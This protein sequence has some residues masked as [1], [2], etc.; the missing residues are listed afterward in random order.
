MDVVL[1]VAITPAAVR[2]VLVEGENADGVTVDYDS[3]EGVGAARVERVLAGI[4]GT[5]AG[6]VE[7]GHRVSGTGVVWTDYAAAVE[8]RAALR[9]RDIEGVTLVSELHAA[10]ALARAVG[11]TA[12]WNSTAL[13]LLDRDTATLAVVRTADGAVTRVQ[14]R[15]LRS[16]DDAGPAEMVT[17]LDDL[18]DAPAA[19]FVVGSEAQ[20][21]EL[22]PIISTHTALPV[23]APA[24]A[25]AA[26]ARGAA[27]AAA[28]APRFDATTVGLLA[29]LETG[30]GTG[31][32]TGEDT[33]PAPDLTHPAGV[34][35]RAPLAYS[36]EPGEAGDAVEESSAEP[37]AA[38]Q[39]PLLLLGSA[40]M[41]VF[42][43]GMVSL[44]VALAVSF[45]PGSDPRGTEGVLPRGSAQTTSAEPAAPPE[46]IQAP[47]PVVREAPRT[48]FVT[49][50]APAPV[51]QR[52]AAVP[53]APPAAVPAPAVPAAP[54]LPAAP[55]PVPAPAPVVIPIPIPVPV[56]APLPAAPP[57]A[58]PAALP[59]PVRSATATPSSAPVSAPVTTTATTASEISETSP[60]TVPS[61]STPTATPEAPAQAPATLIL[62]SEPILPSESVTPES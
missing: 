11:Q 60:A 53:A 32:D 47:V 62:P 49:P 28:N 43:V 39:E 48:V 36:G 22:R 46:T 23:H 51:L 17:G 24:D 29:G 57:A 20:V 19:V 12:G 18:A 44:V 3:V 6:A 56:F 59:T 8:L 34:E 40:A 45:G 9:A 42:V 54:P 33:Q 55:A 31:L 52:P 26:L 4:C 7:D 25:E 1:G 15:G 13:M 61:A 5:R 27:L 2:M 30:L 50:A 58:S 41:A 38:G 21:A 37:D 10:S 35:Y 14:T 16:D